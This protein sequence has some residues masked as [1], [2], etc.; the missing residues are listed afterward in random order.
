MDRRLIKLFCR[1]AVRPKLRPIPKPPLYTKCLYEKLVAEVGTHMT[2]PKD[3]VG[4]LGNLFL[5]VKY[6][7]ILR[8]LKY[9]KKIETSLVT[10]FFVYDEFF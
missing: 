3:F 1:G 2:V 8:A 6:V 4:T 5:I 10:N 9:V 7:Y